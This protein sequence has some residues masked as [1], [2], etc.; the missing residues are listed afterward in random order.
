MSRDVYLPGVTDNENEN[1]D[2]LT[3]ATGLSLIF[4]GQIVEFVGQFLGLLFVF[5]VGPNI[6]L[7]VEKF[8]VDSPEMQR[9]EEYFTLIPFIW[10]IMLVS[11]ILFLVGLVF[12]LTVPPKHVP[13]GWLWGAISIITGIV[14]GI[15]NNKGYICVGLALLCVFSW[16]W[17]L[18]ILAK[19]LDFDPLKKL[20]N[21]F[22]WHSIFSIIFLLGLLFVFEWLATAFFPD[23]VLLITCVWVFI[24][25]VITLALQICHLILIRRIVRYIRCGY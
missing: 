15:V 11:V 8:A 1:S 23:K 17:F 13:R 5:L 19:V 9:L 22:F 7:N 2:L 20:A 3:T 25:Y 18:K 10:G 12:C 24:F 21:Q 16:I 14:A 4:W 6:L